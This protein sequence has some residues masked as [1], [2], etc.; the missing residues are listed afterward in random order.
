[1]R[2]TPLDPPTL[3]HSNF[4]TFNT[5]PRAA[6]EARP[7]YLKRISCLKIS[8]YTSI[9]CATNSARLPGHRAIPVTYV[10]TRPVFREPSTL[11]RR[12]EAA[13]PQSSSFN[14]YALTSPFLICRLIVTCC[15]RMACI[16]KIRLF[17]RPL[18]FQ[19][20]TLNRLPQAAFPQSLLFDLYSLT[21]RPHRLCRESIRNSPKFR[22]TACP[23]IISSYPDTS[24]R[25]ISTASPVT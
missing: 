13:S 16:S 1:M 21:T 12:P 2:L 20:S 14:L 4:F 3:Y 11:N 22:L 15:S 7:P 5:P 9:L 6:S 8:E 19:T 25:V 23:S 18:T 10:L 24:I 17:D